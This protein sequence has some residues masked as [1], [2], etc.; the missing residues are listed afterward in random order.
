MS[1]DVLVVNHCNA[2]GCVFYRTIHHLKNAISIL[3]LSRIA[4]LATNKARVG[5][6]ALALIASVL[7]PQSM[8]DEIGCG[9]GD[10]GAVHVGNGCVDIKCCSDVCSFTPH[11]CDT[12]W[13]EDCLDMANQLCEICGIPGL[14]SCFISRGKASCADATCCGIVC[15]IDPFCCEAVWDFTCALSAQ[16]LC[17]LPP[18]KSCGDPTAGDCL[19]PH[20][21]SSCADPVCCESVCAGLPTCCNV[22]WDDFCV[23]LA[24]DLCNTSCT[25]VCPLNAS[26]ELEACETR[27]N[28][29]SIRPDLILPNT[30]QTIGAQTTMC[31]SLFTTVDGTTITDVDVYYLDLRNADTDNDGYVKVAITLSS[32]RPVFAALTAVNATETSLPGAQVLVNAAGCAPGREWNCVAPAK[33]WVVVAPGTNGIIS[34]QS[35]NC[36]DGDYWFKMETAAKCVVPCTNATGNCFTTHTTPSC[37]DPAC[38]GVVCNSLPSCCETTWDEDCAILAAQSC[39]A[40]SPSNDSCA[41][42]VDVSVGSTSLSLLGS[43]AGL[44]AFSCPSNP[45]PTGSDIW[46]RWTPPAGTHSNYQID[47]CGVNF[48]TRMDLFSGSCAN[49]VLEQCS[50]D[51]IFCEPN[52]GSNLRFETQCDTTYLIR[53][54]SLENSTGFA[55]LRITA[56]SDIR[57]CCVGDFDQNGQIDSGDVSSILLDYGVCFLCPTDLDSSGQVDSGDVS[58]VLLGWGPCN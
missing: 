54:A 18:P 1:H 38:C 14:G 27:S 35:F 21:N 51:S 4:A 7:A 2:R 44:P 47:V 34:S 3:N 46:L 50:D 56:L 23:Y 22:I 8:A 43:T 26:R 53:L 36:D 10:C 52:R 13:D 37:V 42:P 58:T 20:G 16:D 12:N 15:A 9:F 30:A 49:L 57:G 11:C 33:Y 45:T 41:T 6:L 19:V 39:G 5:F 31:G 24:A 25:L 28:D 32:I 48:D 55:T 17:V 40:P 29:P